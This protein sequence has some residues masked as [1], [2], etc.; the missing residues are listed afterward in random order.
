MREVKGGRVRGFHTSTDTPYATN[1]LRGYCTTDQHHLA[2]KF[3]PWY[4][5][6]AHTPLSQDQASAG[7]TASQCFRKGKVQGIG[8]GDNTLGCLIGSLYQKWVDT[9]NIYKCDRPRP[10]TRGNNPKAAEKRWKTFQMA[11]EG[12]VV[13]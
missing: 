3:Y 2:S 6:V 5:N 11:M 12:C 13:L 10:V 7:T 9:G 4:D 1:G 8:T